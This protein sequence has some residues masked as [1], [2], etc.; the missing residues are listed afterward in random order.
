MRN[1]LLA[2]MFILALQG[3]SS[4][5]AAPQKNQDPTMKTIASKHLASEEE[6]SYFTEIIFRPGSS[7][8]SPKDLKAI[9]FVH[10]DAKSKGKI[11]KIQ[12]ITWGDKEYPDAKDKKLSNDQQKLVDQR[13]KSV[14]DYLNDKVEDADVELVSMA[15]RPGAVESLLS[16]SDARLKKSLE[17]SGIPEKGRPSAAEPK[18]GRAIV[19]FNL[20]KED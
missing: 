4:K 1:I 20:E 10:Q 13:N 14:E 6:S 12:V 5:K 18:A 7:K 8:L 9:D 17:T 2:C 15:Q 11:D 16:T 3:C 19:I